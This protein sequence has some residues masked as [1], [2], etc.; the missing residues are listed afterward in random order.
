MPAKKKVPVT[1]AKPIDASNI[2]RHLAEVTPKLV[3]MPLPQLLET[4]GH[5]VRLNHN[6][7]AFLVK[8]SNEVIKNLSDAS[9]EQIS[10]IIKGAGSLI[11]DIPAL[12]ESCINSILFQ[13][14]TYNAKQLANIMTGLAKLDYYD[15]NLM[16]SS[17]SV[18][19]LHKI[20]DA[21]SQDLSSIL[22]SCAKLRYQDEIFAGSWLNKA[23]PITNHFTSTDLSQ[24]IQAMAK[25]GYYDEAFIN[26]WI[27]RARELSLRPF[28]SI[29]KLNNAYYL[30][31]IKVNHAT[32][33]IQASL[34]NIIADLIDCIPNEDII[35][36]EDKRQLLMPVKQLSTEKQA[37]LTDKWD[38]TI[39]TEE[40][41]TR[42]EITVSKTQGKVFDLVN[43]IHGIKAASEHWIED[44]LNHVDIYIEE[45]AA[46]IQVD[47]H[48]SHYYRNGQLTSTTIFNSNISANAGYQILRVK[49]HEGCKKAVKEFLLPLWKAKKASEAS[50]TESKATAED[51]VSNPFVFLDNEDHLLDNTPDTIR[52]IASAAPRS[53]D[54]SVKS[55]DE[56]LEEAI[57]DK[58]VK[59]KIYM[60]LLKA[61]ITS[62]YEALSAHKAHIESC[63][64]PLIA[65]A[66]LNNEIEI[67]K[68]L[69]EHKV[70]PN[71][72]ARTGDTAIHI[73]TSKENY[74]IVETLLE[75]GANPNL[76]SK[77]G[78][79]AVHIAVAQENFEILKLL[80][81]YGS[82]LNIVNNLGLT[83]FDLIHNTPEPTNHKEETK[84]LESNHHKI[85]MC[86]AK[87][88]I[89]DHLPLN[90]YVK[91][92][93]AA[94]AGEVEM[95]QRL[96]L[97]PPSDKA[98]KYNAL[99]EATRSAI[100]KGFAE[101]VD[102]L[103]K[104]NKDFKQPK[105][106][107]KK[108][109][110]LYIAV[111]KGDYAI[112]NL[113]LESNPALASIP[114]NTGHTALHFATEEGQ[115][116][117]VELLLT[118]VP[119]LV[120]LRSSAD[121]TALH[122]ASQKGHDA[123]V[124][125]FL[126][127]DK[128]LVNKITKS[129]YTA[130]HLAA[131][132]G[133]AKTA[134]ILLESNP[135]LA[136]KV[137]K[138]GLTAL[139]IAAGKGHYATAKILLE[140][141]QVLATMATQDG[142]TTLHLAAQEGHDQIV[143]LLLQSQPILAAMVNKY[144]DTALDI[145]EQEDHHKIVALLSKHHDKAVEE[146][147]EE[148]TDACTYPDITPLTNADLIGL[149]DTDTIVMG[150]ALLHN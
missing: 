84:Y 128:S 31:M 135:S 16:Q 39:L 113:L 102:I 125:L 143:E 148:L 51:E 79:S 81:D 40:I 25:L 131:Q 110:L 115:S 142:Y 56:V 70:N 117:I 99:I 61:A 50:G 42:S 132:E 97:S 85:V 27:N 44:I 83:P 88:Q 75:H 13:I 78:N 57:L 116:E 24:S 64:H 82:R 101:V 21:D 127:H 34:D 72:T 7:S 136:I 18:L 93:C 22:W 32:G 9:P 122:V 33:A 140:S 38:L 134:E 89:S 53:P 137:T 149:T 118:K 19:T 76:T 120:N 3:G 71:I 60:G 94:Y 80:A 1:K 144:G 45:F 5:M 108:M 12:T 41:R 49:N 37:L 15:E 90:W 109:E 124:Q 65:S 92:I 107:V 106:D 63:P 29:E 28:S 111:K 66:V 87:Q 141:N 52:P 36:I 147:K 55:D 58:D 43:D 130:L 146:V 98:Q 26:E 145:A 126:N 17:L 139:H 104:A 48:P 46:I 150:E 10:Q 54:V 103:L 23:V 14:D 114:V 86:L 112:T 47:A 77:N 100:F 121:F 74:E 30:T 62:D 91:L 105:Y 2:E 129:G 11:L 8:W 138:A 95:I 20:N 123:I 35:T 67:V 133:N 4:F 69:L 119:D 59:N 68:L 96:I 6:D 73:A